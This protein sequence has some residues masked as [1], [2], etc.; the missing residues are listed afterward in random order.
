MTIYCNDPTQYRASDVIVNGISQGEFTAP[1]E[2]EKI[3]LGEPS[4]SWENYPAN[5]NGNVIPVAYSELVMIQGSTR[6]RIWGDADVTIYQ[7][8]APAVTV[9]YPVN[10]ID[11]I[12]VNIAA[13]NGHQ[14]GVGWTIPRPAKSFTVSAK[15]W[16]LRIN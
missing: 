16:K 13:G 10:D 12:V 3:F 11:P 1:V 6:T 7:T 14:S 8:P 15:R 9:T 2:V 5:Y 4:I